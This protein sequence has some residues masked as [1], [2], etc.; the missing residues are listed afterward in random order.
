MVT[1]LPRV[2]IDFDADSSHFRLSDLAGTY[3]IRSVEMTRT[4]N[5]VSIRNPSRA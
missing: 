2:T 4:N 1:T 5:D 3:D